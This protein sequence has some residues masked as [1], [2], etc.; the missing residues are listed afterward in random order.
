MDKLEDIVILPVGVTHNI[1]LHLRAR[2]HLWEVCWKIDGGKGERGYEGIQR[3]GTC[4]WGVGWC[5]RR[6]AG[7]IAS[8]ACA[9]GFTFN[10]EKQLRVASL[11]H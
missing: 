7:S 8:T 2:V 9:A 3:V 11:L 4:G 1:H 6:H 5:A 10:P